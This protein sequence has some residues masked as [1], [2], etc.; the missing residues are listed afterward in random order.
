[1]K[2]L[3]IGILGLSLH[4]PRSIGGNLGCYALG[5]SFFEIL[6]IIAKQNDI[7]IQIVQI[8]KF[9]LKRCVKQVIK[10]LIRRRNLILE[11][12]SKLYHNLEF[13][14]SDVLKLHDQRLLMSTVKRCDCVFDFTAGDSFTDIYGEERF[15]DRTGLKKKIIEEWNS[16]NIRKPNDRSFQGF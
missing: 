12:Y 1:M 10:R 15:Y 4:S 11:Y 13:I 5:Y 2:K 3:K 7:Q 8:R 9:R 16:F 6:D 14:T